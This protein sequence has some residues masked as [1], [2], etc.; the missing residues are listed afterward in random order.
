MHWPTCNCI[1]SIDLLIES[2]LEEIVNIEKFEFKIFQNEISL[3]LSWSDA[4]S[5]YQKCIKH[6]IFRWKV[7]KTNVLDVSIFKHFKRVPSTLTVYRFRCH[8][9]APIGLN[10]TVQLNC[11]GQ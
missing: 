10:K 11:D 2:L 4:K 3:I 5:I 6:P 8:I 1:A 9:S 7:D